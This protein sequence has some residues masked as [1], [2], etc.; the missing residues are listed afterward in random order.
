MKN[1]KALFLFFLLIGF[2]TVTPAQNIYD[3]ISALPKMERA[4]AFIKLAKSVQTSNFD[5]A[6]EYAKKA[7]LL[8]SSNGQLLEMGLAHKY[9]GL[10]EY[11]RRNDTSA[12]EQYNSSLSIFKKI[13]NETEIGNIL[14]NMAIIYSENANYDTSI[15]FYKKSLAIREKQND[16][17]K[18]ITSMIN[19]GN[20]YQYMGE[21]D[22]SIDYYKKAL[23]T[24]MLVFPEKQFPNLFDGMA[25]SLVAKG[26]MGEASDYFVKAVNSAKKS[27]NAISLVVNL[28]N[29]GN[30]YYS[31][32]STDKAIGCFE[33]ALE[34][35]ADHDMQFRIGVI[36][37]NIGNIYYQTKQYKMA[38]ELYESSLA[39]TK[40]NNDIPGL[41]RGNINVA[42]ANKQLGA[43]DLA[44]EGF[45]KARA[46]AEKIN[47]PEYLSMT[48]NYLGK[49]YLEIKDYDS[50]RIILKKALEIAQANNILREIH[51]ANYNL[52]LYWTELKGFEKSLPFFQSSLS[53][54]EKIQNIEFQKDASEGLWKSYEKLKKYDKAFVAFKTYNV[55]K[56]SLF[57]E[58]KQSQISAVEGRLKLH[59]KEE[60]IE[61][62]NKIIDQQQQILKQERRSKIYI[63][64]VA[65][66]FISLLLLTLNRRKIKRDK[67]KAELL[68]QNLEVERDLLQ[69]QMNPHFIF[70]AMNSIQ[71]FIAVNDSLQAE[72][73]LSKFANLMR[74]YL[75]TSS[76]KWIGLSEEIKALKLNLELER[77]RTNEKFDYEFILD[78]NIEA[79]EIAIPPILMQPFVE[80]AIKHG[81]RPMKSGGFIII[82]F[83]LRKD[84][85]FCYIED[86]GVGRE[87]AG[88]NKNRDSKHVSRGVEI[89][90]D[91]LKPFFSG[92]EKQ[93]N[94]TTIDLKDENGLAIG[95][96]V[97]LFIPIKYC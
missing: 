38:L 1:Y 34:L 17:E 19:I 72:V 60:Q 30:F 54:A 75:E 53:T 73:F 94:I 71:A 50:S 13:N 70:N 81:I 66:L 91:R 18:I 84:Y 63:I 95:T 27:G 87:R 80:N 25:R 23:K 3:S 11:Y 32:G 6:D 47:E 2:N 68:K 46:L 57:N 36:K 16:A 64:A 29:I 96:R 90:K 78:E 93:N 5:L 33:E 39:S 35:A 97:E 41:I 86:N 62:Q 43:M 44:K 12:M 69:L 65:A 48:T 26:E 58:E 67:E 82:G 79:E 31:I 8:A 40:K 61:N 4:P 51:M 92:K 52:G 59:L 74:Y 77:L 10:T 42:L 45:L 56:D 49:Y 20:L 83:E 14:N 21:Y 24:A 15:D 9:M 37:L 85:L 88:K 28:V 7:L 22:K 55:M 76:K 89:T